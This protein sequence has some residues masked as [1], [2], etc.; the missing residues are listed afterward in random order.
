MNHSHITSYR[1][2]KKLYKQTQQHLY[3]ETHGIHRSNETSKRP[4]QKNDV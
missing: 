4:Q 2:M 3:N 1:A